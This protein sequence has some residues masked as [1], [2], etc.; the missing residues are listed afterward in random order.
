MTSTAVTL[1][2]LVHENQSVVIAGIHEGGATC[3]RIVVQCLE[4]ELTSSQEL[5]LC[6]RCLPLGYQKPTQKAAGVGGGW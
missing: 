5:E 4:T 2:G 6:A 3:F 1:A